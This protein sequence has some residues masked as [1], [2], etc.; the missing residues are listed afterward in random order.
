M[1]ITCEKCG[2]EVI[3]ARVRRERMGHIELVA[4]VCHIWYLKGIPSYLGLI[5]DMA[6]KDLERVIYFDA[7][8]VINQG[9]SPYP[10]KHFLRLLNMIAIQICIQKIVNLKLKRVLKQLR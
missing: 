5:L 10:E 9:K 2:V 3:Q 7:Y 1:V 6:I 8:L 4:P